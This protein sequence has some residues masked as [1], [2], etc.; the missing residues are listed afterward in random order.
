L[1]L[2]SGTKLEIKNFDFPV[3]Y[4]INED[5]LRFR[6]AS[7]IFSNQGR[8]ETRHGFSKFNDTSLGGSVL[9]QS[10]FKKTDDTRIVLAKIDTII[11]KVAASGAHTNLKTGLTSANKH[12]GI[13]LNNRH[14]VSVEDDGLFSYDGTNFT[15]LGQAVPSSPSVAKV[16]GGSLTDSTYQVAVTFYDSINGFE[17]NIGA[18]STSIATETTNNTINVT[19]IPTTADN[20][21][22][23]KV[24]V[25]FKDVTNDGAWLF[26][27]EINLG[28][29]TSSIT[30]DATSTQTPPTKNGAVA[31]GGGKYL[32]T[33][34]RKLVYAGNDTFKNDVF[35]SEQDLPDAY[36]DDGTT[37]TR[38]YAPGNGSISGIAT[39]FFNDGV[40]DPYLVVFKRGS[41]HVYSEV[42]GIA[43]FEPISGEIGCVSDQTISVRNGDV[44]FLSANGWRVIRNGKL[45]T[46]K[47]GNPITLSGGDLDDIFTSPGYVYEINKAESENF[48]SV[49]YPTLDQYITWVSEGTVTTKTKAYVY[50]FRTGGFKV[51]NFNT[52][53]VSS[54]EY[55]NDSGIDMVLFGDSAGW[56]YQ[57][58]VA[59]N[60][61]DT[62]ADDE[63]VTIAAFGLVGW[64]DGGD[65]DATYSFR[66]LILRAIA[67]SDTLTVKAFFN[68]NISDASERDY[69]FTD[70]LSGFILDISKLDEGTF[71]D[72]RNVVTSRGDINRTAENIMVG[73]YQD[74]SGGNIGLSA[75]QIFFSK[76]GNRNT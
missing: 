13:T 1:P 41:I 27:E 51:Y 16:A 35:F 52:A 19:S 10:F 3:S 2:K 73:F 6:D 14:I 12:R 50:E 46:D 11:K 67:D 42:G 29:S 26:W 9:S 34:N 56:I 70:P 64:V 31:A 55:D 44:Y 22:I 72:G 68:F 62:N 45:I 17:T 49:F 61:D 57:H 71:S 54:T 58:S 59:E 23:D 60:R 38:L 48:F 30:T 18:A 37:Q 74:E 21:N 40:L 15:Q 53:A 33:F 65:F 7:N 24:R 43:K 76:N 39:G 75:L 66:E 4:K 5:R 8:M 47:G 36:D 32:T 28:T 25:Y 69:T 63:S 20:A